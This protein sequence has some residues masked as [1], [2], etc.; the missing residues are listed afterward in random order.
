MT[1][2]LRQLLDDLDDALTDW[3]R[4]YAADMCS[5]EKVAQSLRR[6]NDG[7]GTLYYIAALRQRINAA[8]TK[9]R[10]ERARY[11]RQLRHNNRQPSRRV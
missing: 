1:A 4:T 6:I 11:M 7:G 3:I 10:D 9:D 5:Q 2:N 8:L